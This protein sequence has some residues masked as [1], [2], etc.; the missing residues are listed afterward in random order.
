MGEG[1]LKS[2]QKLLILD[3]VQSVVCIAALNLL[4]KSITK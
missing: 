3:S 1:K 4:L 2:F